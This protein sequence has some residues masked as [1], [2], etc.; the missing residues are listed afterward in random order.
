M[1][2][3][4][5]EIVEDSS[6]SSI[7]EKEK[8]SPIKKK[9]SSLFDMLFVKKTSSLENI[10]DDKKSIKDKRRSFEISIVD[11]NKNLQFTHYQL[12]DFLVHGKY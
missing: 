2:K 3:L 5:E 9:T 8:K 7:D 12:K 1:N 4:D 11:I 6:K 10:L